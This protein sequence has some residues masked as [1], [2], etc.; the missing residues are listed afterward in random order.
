MINDVLVLFPV[1]EE[2]AMLT[3]FVVGRALQPCQGGAVLR[4]CKTLTEIARV[5][6]LGAVANKMPQ[7]LVG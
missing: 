3:T 1:E 7:L 4:P 5:L 2:C 6:T